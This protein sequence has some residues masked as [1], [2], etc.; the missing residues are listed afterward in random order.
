[1]AHAYDRVLNFSAGPCILPVPVLEEVQ[2]DLINYKGSGKS[3]LEMSHRG[4]DYDAIIKQTEADLR[5]LMGIPENYK[6][7]FLQGGASMQFTMLAMNFLG[8]GNHAD[9]VLTGAWGAKAIESA[10][11]VGK[12]DVLYDA[13]SSN[14]N[15]GPDLTALAQTPGAK[16]FHFTSNETIQGVEIFGDHDLGNRVIVDAS[17]DI[18]S[19][20]IDVSKYA[21]I[22][23]GAQKNMGPA[24]CTLVVMREDMLDEIPDGLAPML[25]YRIHAK[26]GSM[27]NT[28]PCFSIYVMGLVYKW[29]LG[30]G[31][32]TAIHKMNQEKSG[33]LYSAIDNSNGFFKGHAVAENRSLMNVTFTLPSDE[34]TAEFLKEAK[35][36]KMEELNGHRSVGG[37][38]ASI[39]NGFPKQGC[40]ELAAFMTDFAKR[41]G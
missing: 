15:H 8:A 1:M 31:G 12:A 20:P 16:Y 26:N 33:V 7:L 11:L 9:Y 17:S 13:K 29:M 22:Y 25:D 36:N 21:V 38:R 30:L 41:N 19:R 39:Y 34:L 14:Y 24:G 4:K 35:A 27:Y 10:N 40:D 23:A 37:C 28:P 5:S 2:K 6:V 3:V 32:L 18:L